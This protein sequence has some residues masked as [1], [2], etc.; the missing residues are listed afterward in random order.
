MV[1]FLS[2]IDTNVVGWTRTMGDLCDAEIVKDKLKTIRPDTIFHLASRPA[3]ESESSWIAI[4]QEMQ[5][6]SNIAHS[7]PAHCK[8]I[9]VG[10]MAEYGRSGYFSEDDPCSPNTVYGCAK[11]SGTNLAAALRSSLNLDIRTARLFGVF[12]PGEAHTRLLPAL[13]SRLQK[14]DTI[15]LSNGLQIRDF[16][17]VD[18]VCV[19]LYDFSKLTWN[20]T[21]VLN[22]GTG[23]GVTVRHVC[24]TIANILGADRS[25]LH[26][27]KIER[28]YVDQDCLVTKTDQLSKLLS[29][30][31]QRWADPKLAA[32]CV[33]QFQA[34]P[35]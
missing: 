14:R 3:I 23:I 30:P 26:F 24:E 6:L 35:I 2:E 33:S 17:H 5:M 31:L 21:S 22:I 32:E 18:D 34:T 25:L 15:A 27:G 11:F 16:V 20:E 9:Y 1:R 12:G 8:L 29:V 4:A 13:I 28:R 10:S 7:M 19:L